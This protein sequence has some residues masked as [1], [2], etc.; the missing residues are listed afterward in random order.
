MSKNIHFRLDEEWIERIDQQAAALGVP[1]ASLI[2]TLV[3]Q[4]MG[5]PATLAVLREAHYRVSPIIQRAVARV[6]T[7]LH[8][9]LPVALNEEMA[10]AGY[11]PVSDAAE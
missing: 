9:E 5:E 1:R 4:A 7:G 6:L 8:A 2:R 10:A 3:L 11:E